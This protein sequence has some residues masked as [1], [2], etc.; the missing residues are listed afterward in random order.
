MKITGILISAFLLNLNFTTTMV[1][2]CEDNE[3]SSEETPPLAAGSGTIF[4]GEMSVSGVL[5]SHITPSATER[6]ITLEGKKGLTNSS[7][8]HVRYLIDNNG[9]KKILTLS[10]DNIAVNAFD[11]F[12]RSTDSKSMEN[13]G[14]FNVSP[15][16][17]DGTYSAGTTEYILWRTAEGITGNKPIL[18]R[19]V[20][21]AE[22]LALT[23]S[24][25]KKDLVL[26]LTLAE[27]LTV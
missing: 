13:T 8:F 16:L 20:P 27:E 5:N 22:F 9:D 24:E 21:Y 14:V 1:Y 18:D 7:F 15:Y 17:K 10:I 12:S 6:W 3:M 2:S 19:S 23:L 4:L 25:D 11:R 26:T